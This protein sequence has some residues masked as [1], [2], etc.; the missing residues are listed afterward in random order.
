MFHPSLGLSGRELLNRYYLSEKIESAGN[1]VLLEN[2]EYAIIESAFEKVKGFSQNDVE[3]VK[4]VLE[5][6]IVEI[7]EVE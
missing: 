7:K 1:S 2:S 4:R 6:E 3:L 5:A